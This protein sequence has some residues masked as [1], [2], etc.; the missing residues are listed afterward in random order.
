MDV[1]DWNPGSD[2]RFQ[3][4]I[5]R[6]ARIPI[7]SYICGEIIRSGFWTLKLRFGHKIGMNI[8][9]VLRILI[10]SQ[11]LGEANRKW[12]LVIEIRV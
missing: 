1:G 4:N 11:V 2:T 12:M 6:D 3:Q 8:G 5:R 10:K 9:F 7:Q